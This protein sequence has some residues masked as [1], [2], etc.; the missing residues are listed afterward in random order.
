[1]QQ[2]QAGSVNMPD[3]QISLPIWPMCLLYLPA[4]AVAASS[5]S[6][7]ADTI[8]FPQ[9]LPLF[10]VQPVGVFIPGKSFSA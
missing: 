6:T 5:N 8:T 9:V 7:S 10:P 4:G 1:V 2:V 3:L